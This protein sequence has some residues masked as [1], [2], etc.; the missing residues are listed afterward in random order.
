MRTTLDIDE[1]LLRK[2][3]AEAR[4]RDIS[5]KELVNQVIRRGL[6]E[7]PAEPREPYRCP[8]FSMGVPLRSIDKALALADALEEDERSWKLAQRK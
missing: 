2:L 7:R 8:T 3:R 5:L 4:A 6:E 1:H